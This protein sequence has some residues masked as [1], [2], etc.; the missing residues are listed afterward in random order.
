MASMVRSNIRDIAPT[1]SALIGF[2]NQRMHGHAHSALHRMTPSDTASSDTVATN[3]S[4]PRPSAGTDHIQLPVWRPAAERGN[5]GQY[6]RGMAQR[7][8]L[9][10]PAAD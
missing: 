6:V 3:C 8:M 7:R 1:L 10:H 4:S 5:F 9:D 2:E